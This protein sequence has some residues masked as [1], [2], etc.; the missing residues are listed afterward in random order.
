MSCFETGKE[1]A[2]RQSTRIHTN[3]KDNLAQRRKDAE[4]GEKEKA[5]KRKAG[6]DIFSI[7]GKQQP[8]FPSE[9][10]GARQTIPP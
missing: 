10:R 5:K 8:H 3:E 1:Q 7:E 2:I 6:A 4:D 9:I